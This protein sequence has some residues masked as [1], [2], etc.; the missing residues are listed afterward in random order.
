MNNSFLCPAKATP[1][2]YS[3]PFRPVYG[4]EKKKVRQVSITP[5]K[6]HYHYADSSPLEL[7]IEILGGGNSTNPTVGA[8]HSKLIRA[9]FARTEDWIEGRDL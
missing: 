8:R 2:T 5:F 7:E 4:I 1:N 3:N 9:A 6:A